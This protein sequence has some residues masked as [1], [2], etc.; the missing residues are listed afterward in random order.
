[1]SPDPYFDAFDKSIDVRKYDLSKH[2]TAGLC[3]TQT[4]DRLFLEGMS[5]S[6]PGA[7]I[8]RWRTRLK[9]A[10]LIKVGDTIVNS[11]ED[12]QTAFAQESTSNPGNVILLFSHP[13]V[14]PDISYDGLPIVLSAPS[15]NTYM[16]KSTNAGI[17]PLLLNTSRKLRPTILW[18]TVMS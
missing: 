13:E 14:R 6:T 3:L 17:S 1:M 12:A 11:I 9:G 16:T 4:D 8:P 7:K 10:W 5:P 2:R 18:T 15:P